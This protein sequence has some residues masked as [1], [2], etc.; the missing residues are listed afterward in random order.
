[1]HRGAEIPVESNSLQHLPE[2]S[3]SLNA[4]PSPC[5]LVDLV[6]ED[7]VAPLPPP[8]TKVSPHGLPTSMREDMGLFPHPPAHHAVSVPADTH[9][10]APG[11]HS[12]VG[13]SQVDVA[14][15]GAH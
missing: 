3:P 5:Q 11:S 15:N 7:P 13:G 12:Q 1:M 14:S 2:T 4:I 6:M 8:G 10:Q 9:P